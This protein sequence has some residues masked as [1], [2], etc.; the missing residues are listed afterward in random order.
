MN[1]LS[2]HIMYLFVYGT[3]KSQFDNEMAKFLRQEAKLVGEASVIGHLYLLGWY[4]GLVLD[5]DGYEI[6][7]EV[8][9]LNEESEDILLKLD[10]YEG[11][12]Q[13][14]YRRIKR[15]IKVKDKEVN[16]WIYESLIET[17]VEL[18]TGEFH[19]INN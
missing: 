13:G 17:D 8:Y 9:Q 10:D 3:L 14:D 5:A 7:G 15:K 16:C 12:E 2:I 6:K 19:T 11:V 18:K 4:P 1:D